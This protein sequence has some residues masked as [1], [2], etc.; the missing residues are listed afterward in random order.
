M[1]FLNKEVFSE[2]IIQKAMKKLHLP[3]QPDKV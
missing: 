2:K 1:D 3:F